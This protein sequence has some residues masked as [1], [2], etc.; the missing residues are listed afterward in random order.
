M[1]PG[2]KS[3]TPCGSMSQAARQLSKLVLAAQ[4][5]VQAARERVALGLQHRHRARRCQG[6]HAW[7][8]HWSSLDCMYRTKDP[9]QWY[10]RQQISLNN[11]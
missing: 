2:P 9:K 5:A 10:M 4:Q 1:S 3:S 7:R 6:P 8:Q 11:E